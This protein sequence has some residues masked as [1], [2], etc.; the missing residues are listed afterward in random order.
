MDAR[1]RLFRTGASG[2]DRGV[3]ALREFQNNDRPVRWWT[4]SVPVDEDSGQIAVRLPGYKSGVGTF[5]DGDAMNL[6]DD[7]ER[8]EG[9]TQW[10]R[11]YLQGLYGATRTLKNQNSSRVEIASSL[12]GARHEMDLDPGQGQ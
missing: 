3:R 8:T 9:L 1:P 2:T 10:D 4:V 12:V 6:F 5:S 11:A 7:P